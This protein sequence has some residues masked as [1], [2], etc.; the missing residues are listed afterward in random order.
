MSTPRTLLALNWKMN[1]TPTEAGEWAKAL[2]EELPQTDAE[3]VVCAP[4]VTLSLVAAHL[5]GSGA[6]LGAQDV[7]AHESGAYTGETSAAMLKDVGAAYV[8]V[9]HSERRT[10]HGETDAVV[11]AKAR[12]AL[13][14][15]LTPIVC[16]GEGLDVREAGE[17]VP[18][19]LAQ[20]RSSLE[21]VQPGSAEQLVIAYEPV[22]AIG[23]GRTA[24]SADAEELAAAIRGALREVYPDFA[25]GVRVLYGGSVKPD[26]IADICAQPN[27]NGALVGGAALDL[28]SVLS[29]VEALA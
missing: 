22:W 11:A 4:A 15:G 2:Q 25:D 26:N 14:H 9:G 24:T 16:V 29:M 28:R 12:K 6:G 19:T 20:L 1:K 13:E 5:Y 7:S 3:L 27:V 23:T 10:Y 17:H 18:Y 21:G 8:I